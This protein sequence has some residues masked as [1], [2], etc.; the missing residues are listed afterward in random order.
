MTKPGSFSCWIGLVAV[1]WSLAGCA[2]ST[3]VRAS[4]FPQAVFGAR[5]TTVCG[6][7]LYRGG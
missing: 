1:A 6:Q 7:I 4:P 3:S 2:P 5:P